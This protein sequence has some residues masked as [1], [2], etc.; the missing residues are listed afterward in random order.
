MKAPLLQLLIAS[1]FL[2]SSIRMKAQV[3]FFEEHIDFELDSTYFTINGIFSFC[4]HTD[5][6]L[7]QQIVF[8][9]Q[10]PAI[11]IDSIRLLNLSVG[12]SIAYEGRGKSI[13]FMFELPPRDTVELNI[14]YRQR[15]TAINRYII[16]STQTWRKPLEKAVYTLTVHRPLEP[17]HFTYKPD[18]EE[19]SNH[20]RVYR[21]NKHTFMPFEEFEVHL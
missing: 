1:L 19:I 20:Q 8:P 17:R 3:S 13:W 6:P 16:T 11:E 9:F 21:W 14:Y 7:Q 10:V 2:F 5:R 15:T 4:N 18:S 12:R